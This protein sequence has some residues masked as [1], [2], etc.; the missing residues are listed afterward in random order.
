MIRS[1]IIPG[2]RL[3]ACVLSTLVDQ[4]FGGWH[5]PECFD[6]EAAAPAASSSSY[7]MAEISESSGKKPK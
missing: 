6:E 1:W 3:V 7:A 2:A 5:V 4:Q